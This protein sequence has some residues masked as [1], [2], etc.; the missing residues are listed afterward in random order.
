LWHNTFIN[1]ANTKGNQMTNIYTNTEFAIAAT[2]TPISKGYAVTL[3]DTDSEQI[4]G[5]RIYPSDRKE[6]AIA[7]AKFL[8]KVI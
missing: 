5:S 4:V 7:Y 3:I 1:T 2:V 6:D 8:V